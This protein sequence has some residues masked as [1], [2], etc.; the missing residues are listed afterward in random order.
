M[1][2]ILKLCGL[3]DFDHVAPDVLENAKRR[4]AAV[5]EWTEWLDEGR[6]HE[7]DTP[8]TDIA[9]YVAAYVAF[10]REASFE[11]SATEQVVISDKYRYAGTLDRAGYFRASRNPKERYVLD[12]KCVATV[13]P[14]TR[15]QLSGYALA[16]NIEGRAALQLKPNGTY[17]L[18][19]Y[20]DAIDLTDWLCCVRVAHF[21]LRHGMAP[22]QE[23]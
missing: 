13:S 10:K 5:H 9:G 16:A 18:T 21:H 8:S 14:A 15:L 1:T 3:S 20:R 11:V 4:G 6:V 23:D 17:K 7:S 19:R 2:E 22:D 12:L